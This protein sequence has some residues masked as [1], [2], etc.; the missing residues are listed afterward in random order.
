M[1]INYL[2]KVTTIPCL[3][4]LSSFSHSASFNCDGIKQ[5]SFEALICSSPELNEL[6]EKLSLQY[7][8]ALNSFNG[9]DLS[10]LPENYN[11]E[12]LKKIIKTTQREWVKVTRKNEFADAISQAY[13]QRIEE[14]EAFYQASLGTTFDIQCESKKQ[15]CQQVS[16]LNSLISKIYKQPDNKLRFYLPFIIEDLQCSNHRFIGNCLS[17]LKQIGLDTDFLIAHAQLNLFNDFTQGCNSSSWLDYVDCVV[18]TTAGWQKI[19][20]ARTIKIKKAMQTGKDCELSDRYY[21]EYPYG[22]T[23]GA[24]DSDMEQLDSF[25]MA[26]RKYASVYCPLKQQMELGSQKTSGAVC[27]R[28]LAVKHYKKLIEVYGESHILD[29]VINACGHKQQ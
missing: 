12:Q 5:Q 21:Q 16:E 24:I 26:S 13:Q 29:E 20:A 19:I 11:N 18:A 14:L 25:N 3:L 7:R 10:H 17:K 15:N 8:K 6:D 4:L 9:P 2:I 23:V 27:E 28:D 22:M 1:Y